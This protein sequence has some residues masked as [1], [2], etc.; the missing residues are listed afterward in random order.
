M[1]ANVAYQIQAAACRYLDSTATRQVHLTET[2]SNVWANVLP[3]SGARRCRT[4]GRLTSA[5]CG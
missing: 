5:A 2:P 1:V 4:V 3:Q